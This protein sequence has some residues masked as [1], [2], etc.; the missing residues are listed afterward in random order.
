[1]WPVLEQRAAVPTLDLRAACCLL[2]WWGV[3]LQLVSA[4]VWG[5]IRRGQGYMRPGSKRVIFL[6][7]WYYSGEATLRSTI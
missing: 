2:A 6:R 1:M 7:Y 5:A 4:L 3:E